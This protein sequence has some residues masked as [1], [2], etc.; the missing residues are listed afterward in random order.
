MKRLV[1]MPSQR[2]KFCLFEWD[3]EKELF[4]KIADGTFAKDIGYSTKILL[5]NDDADTNLYIMKDDCLSIIPVHTQKVGFIDDVCVYERN[6]QWY[7]FIN[8]EEILLGQRREL[9]LSLSAFHASATGGCVLYYFIQGDVEKDYTLSII[10]N[11]ILI[12]GKYV[13][14]FRYKGDYIFARLEDGS[15]D[16][17]KA[18]AL[19]VYDASYP[20]EGYP[21]VYD[22]LGCVY[23]W[24]EA[25]RAWKWVSSKGKALAKN[26]VLINCYNPKTN[27]KYQVL[28][29]VDS[30]AALREIAQGHFC[31]VSRNSRFCVGDFVYE[32]DSSTQK[33]DFE[34][35]RATF[36]KKVKS[37]L[38]K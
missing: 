9:M 32:I 33:V 31:F 22:D 7:C 5:G 6:E 2:Q 36:K 28:Y 19:C 35:P 21:Y 12:Q 29:E 38:G 3:S 14:D 30:N 15:Y 1:L 25:R 18:G 10:K 24:N 20:Q 37:F 11:S 13:G 26:A 34:N 27:K 4:T 8:E 17:Y 16:V 23:F